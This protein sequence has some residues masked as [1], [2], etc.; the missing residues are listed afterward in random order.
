MLFKE[1]KV[2]EV[3]TLQGIEF[4]KTSSDYGLSKGLTDFYDKPKCFDQSTYV[5]KVNKMIKIVDCPKPTIADI[6]IG[7]YFKINSDFK[8]LKTGGP[9]DNPNNLIY[10]LRLH[11]FQVFTT[12]RDDNTQVT[13]ITQEEAFKS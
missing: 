1:I 3:F 12:R 11:D 2:G 8:F 10:F 9:N 6:K 13:I 7:T 5:V 4:I